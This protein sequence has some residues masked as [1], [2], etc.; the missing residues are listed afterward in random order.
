M[1]DPDPTKQSRP[2]DLRRALADELKRQAPKPSLQMPLRAKVSLNISPT[3][4]PRGAL[5]VDTLL[6]DVSASFRAEPDL[7]DLL[8]RLPAQAKAAVTERDVIRQAIQNDDMVKFSGGILEIPELGRVTTIQE[9]GFGEQTVAAIVN[10][11]TDEAVFLCKQMILL[12][13]KAAGFQRR[14]SDIEPHLGAVSYTTTTTVNMPLPLRDLLSAEFRAF[15]LTDVSGSDGLGREMGMLPFVARDREETVRDNAVVTHLRGLELVVS[16]F[17]K[18]TGD[19]EDCAL[20]FLIH[21]R[22][23]ANRSD[24]MVTSALSSADHSRLVEM[25]LKRIGQFHNK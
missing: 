25:L 19:A 23:D 13:W 20:N 24:V 4:L 1:P 12:M 22:T 8:R 6:N 16:V 15:V 14:W 5:N 2:E 17:N 18:T 10:G 11:T 21:R 9:M 7:T 3:V